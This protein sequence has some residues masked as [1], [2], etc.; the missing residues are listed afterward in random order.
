MLRLDAVL[1]ILGMAAVT[2]LTRVGGL[3]IMGRVPVGERTRAWLDHVPGAVLVSLVLPDLVT[4]GPRSWAAGAATVGAAL[5]T[6]NLLISMVTG[7]GVLFL[8]RNFLP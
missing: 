1:A 2:Y 4:G 3:L 7:V 5:A 6:R 8:L